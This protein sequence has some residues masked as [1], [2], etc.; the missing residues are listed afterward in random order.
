MEEA[1]KVDLTYI[2][3]QNNKNM[4]EE[5]ITGY[6][7]HKIKEI[8]ME[9]YHIIGRYSGI[10]TCTK[11]RNLKRKYTNKYVFGRSCFDYAN[12]IA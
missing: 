8:D 5:L 6:K 4:V 3:D 1:D 12:P 7:I 9:L 11:T 10:S 2:I